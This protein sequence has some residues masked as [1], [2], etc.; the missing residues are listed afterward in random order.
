MELIKEQIT[1]DYEG[2]KYTADRATF[3]QAE[4]ILDQLSKVG[5]D[6]LKALKIEKEFLM[7]SGLSE[8]LI[9]SL[10]MKHIKM[11]FEEILGTKKD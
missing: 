1:F 5:N 11:L 10:Q 9:K 4:M 6:G 2:E 3:A 8:D 7:A